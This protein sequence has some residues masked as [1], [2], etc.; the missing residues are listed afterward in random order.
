MHHVSYGNI[1]WD[2]VDTSMIREFSW[3]LERAKQFVNYSRVLG[4]T[5]MTYGNKSYEDVWQV[6]SKHGIVKWYV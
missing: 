1:K 3:E 4:V 6:D 5:G 2:W